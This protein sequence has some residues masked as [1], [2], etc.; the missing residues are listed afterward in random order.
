MSKERP[1]SQTTAKR[2]R[3]AWLVLAADGTHEVIEGYSIERAAR[4][5]RSVNPGREIVGVLSRDAVVHA[6]P[7]NKTSWEICLFAHRNNSG[8]SSA[9]AKT[10]GGG[11]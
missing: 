8:G 3:R 7:F 2:P 1:Q 4:Y 9:K 10:T 6:S 5:Y 11:E